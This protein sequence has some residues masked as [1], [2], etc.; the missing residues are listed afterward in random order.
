[1]ETKNSE[2]TKARSL[3]FGDMISLYIKLCIC[4]FGGATS[5]GLGQMHLKLVIM[6]LLS[7]FNLLRACADEA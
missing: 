7:D 3:I 2:T 4:I 6:N 1:M 5:R